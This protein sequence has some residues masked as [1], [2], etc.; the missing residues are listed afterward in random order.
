MRYQPALRSVKIR[1]FEKAH[2][3]HFLR[4]CQLNLLKFLRFFAR[5]FWPC[6]A[7]QKLSLLS[8]RRP[9]KSA[10]N[11]TTPLRIKNAA[12]K[13]KIS[14]LLRSPLIHRARST[15][16]NASRYEG[17]RS[18]LNTTFCSRMSV[19]RRILRS[20]LERWSS[21]SRRPH[22]VKFRPHARRTSISQSRTTPSKANPSALKF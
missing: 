9:C 16:A 1:E 15:K 2:Y 21:S 7:S 18:A 12:L 17:N 4:F 20:L 11:E 14:S 22:H 19:L 5:F 13:F 3:I 8:C 6:L 10:T